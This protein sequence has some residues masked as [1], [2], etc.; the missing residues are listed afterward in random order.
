MTTGNRVAG[1]RSARDE[2]D[3][4]NVLARLLERSAVSAEYAVKTR[5]APW[6]FPWGARLINPGCW[7]SST[8]QCQTCPIV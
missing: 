3:D 6:S 5:I 7:M 2:P 1:S 8:K 4:E